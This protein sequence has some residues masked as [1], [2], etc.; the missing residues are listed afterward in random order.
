VVK[1]RLPQSKT[2]ARIRVT[3]VFGSPQIF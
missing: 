2:L 1:Q 3:P